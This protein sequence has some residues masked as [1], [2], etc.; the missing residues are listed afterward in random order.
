MTKKLQKYYSHTAI[1]FIYSDAV[2]F[3]LH[4]KTQ[5]F[6]QQS[7]SDEDVSKYVDGCPDR[8]LSHYED[9]EYFSTSTSVSTR[10]RYYDASMMTTTKCSIQFQNQAPMS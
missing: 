3:D 10:K 2:L 9:V 7:W 6:K 8:Y 4:L 1:S 5:L